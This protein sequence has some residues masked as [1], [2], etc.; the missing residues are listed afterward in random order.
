MYISPNVEWITLDTEGVICAS[1][2]KL[3]GSNWKPEEEL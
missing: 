2:V 1:E 3:P